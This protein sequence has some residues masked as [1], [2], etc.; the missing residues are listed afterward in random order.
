[1]RCSWSPVTGTRRIRVADRKARSVRQAA[2]LQRPTGTGRRL[3]AVVEHDLA[4]H[5]DD[6]DPDGS[7]RRLRRGP[8]VG[9]RPGIEDDE[10]GLAASRD[11]AS[12]GEAEAPRGASGHLR[13]SVLERHHAL[14]ADV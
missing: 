9:Y 12:I 4:V 10:I 2:A 1:M 3:D 7:L 11:D 5:D 6:V 13:D 8:A 14:F